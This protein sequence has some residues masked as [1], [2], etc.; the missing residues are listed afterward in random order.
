MKKGY[1]ILFLGLVLFSA[2]GCDEEEVKNSSGIDNREIGKP[3]TINYDPEVANSFEETYFGMKV[4]FYIPPGIEDLRNRPLMFTLSTLRNLSVAGSV[5]PIINEYGMIAVA[6]RE[7]NPIQFAD[8]LKALIDT[9]YIDPDQVFV[10]GFS[11]GG[12]DIFELAWAQQD[13]VKGAILLD[14]SAFFAG[15]PMEESRLSVCI[16]CQDDREG[17]YSA[18]VSKMNEAGVKTKMIP[19]EGQDHFGI[20]SSGTIEQKIECFNF[21]NGQD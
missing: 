14:P 7:G 21:L 4:A 9:E 1:K 13:K 20:L 11:N 2:S 19:V 18:D 3:I 15:D 12:R 16:V 17:Q 5:E 8:M 10:A 6:P